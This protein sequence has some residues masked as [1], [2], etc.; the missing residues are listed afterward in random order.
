MFFTLTFGWR[1]FKIFFFFFLTGITDIPAKYV[2]CSQ[3][4]KE[5]LET[6]E[7][8]GRSFNALWPSFC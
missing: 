8:T 7:E 4:Y 5:V 3:T 6:L 2:G 1:H